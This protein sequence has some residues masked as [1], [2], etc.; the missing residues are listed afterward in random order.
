MFPAQRI[1]RADVSVPV[2]L[3][4]AAA[5]TRTI[6]SDAFALELALCGCAGEWKRLLGCCKGGSGHKGSGAAQPGKAFRA[7]CKRSGSAA[8]VSVFVWPVGVGRRGLPSSRQAEG[9]CHRESGAC[10][11]PCLSPVRV[12]PSLP[13]RALP[14]YLPFLSEELEIKIRRGALQLLCLSM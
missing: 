5:A 8:Q 6:A 4:A 9:P 10:T 14:L 13:E 1:S 3:A 7:S 11:L 2:F 12:P